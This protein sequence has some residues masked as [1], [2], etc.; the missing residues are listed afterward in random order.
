[1]RPPA[2]QKQ[3][4][5]PSQCS[6]GRQVV[7]LQ[8]MVFRHF[9]H[10]HARS[11]TLGHDPRPDLIPPL[12]IR[13]TSAPP[14]PLNVCM[15]PIPLMLGLNFTP[16]SQNAKQRWLTY[17]DGKVESA[18]LRKSRKRTGRRFC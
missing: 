8:T 5:L 17:R 13:P 4:A 1:M 2:G 7:C 11:R 12:A 9:V 15:R 6:P 16:G 3:L 14:R 18:I 10:R